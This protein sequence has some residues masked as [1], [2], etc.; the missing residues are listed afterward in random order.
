MKNIK[1]DKFMQDVLIDKLNAFNYY[2][3]YIQ[4]EGANNTECIVIFNC[5][6]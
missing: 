6:K 5:K 1:K 3:L 4:R 2:K